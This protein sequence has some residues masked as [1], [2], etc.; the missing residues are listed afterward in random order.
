MKAT[1]QN[2]SKHQGSG[3]WNRPEVKSVRERQ[4]AGNVLLQ[5][6]HEQEGRGTLSSK[7]HWTCCFC[8]ATWWT[9]NNTR[10][11]YVFRH[12][13]SM[14]NFPAD[15]FWTRRLGKHPDKLEE[16]QGCVACDD[17]DMVHSV[18]PFRIQLGRFPDVGT[19]GSSRFWPKKCPREHIA[20][21]WVVAPDKNP[22]K[23]LRLGSQ[24]GSLK[25]PWIRIGVGWGEGSVSSFLKIEMF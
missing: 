11:I 15:S 18:C 4:V 25:R 22:G 10:A 21:H 23:C 6:Q 9:T 17:W 2:G 3:V 20:L 12:V 13:L 14:V 24:G 1:R 16:R 8:N 7:C 5:A 19:N